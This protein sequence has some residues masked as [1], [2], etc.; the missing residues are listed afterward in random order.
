MYYSGFVSK[1]TVEHLV[2]VLDISLQ[3]GWRNVFYAC[4][5]LVLPLKDYLSCQGRFSVRSLFSGSVAA[6]GDTS[7]QRIAGMVSQLSF[8]TFP[9]GDSGRKMVEELEARLKLRGRTV[10][11]SALYFGY[12]KDDSVVMHKAT[13]NVLHFFLALR[14]ELQ[15]DV[16]PYIARVA[17][18]EARNELSAI[19]QQTLILYE[20]VTWHCHSNM[21]RMSSTTEPV[22]LASGKLWIVNEYRGPYHP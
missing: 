10:D 22:P 15:L 18:L 14:A 8:L 7:E 13:E 16:L 6:A 9:G 20:L 1:L 11:F 5:Q 4:D 17:F 19:L 21:E 3:I 12:Q 2:D